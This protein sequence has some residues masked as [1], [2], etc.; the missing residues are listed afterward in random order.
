MKFTLPRITR[1]TLILLVGLVG[2]VN[3]TFI[4]ATPREV[5]VWL[6]GGFVL[7]IPFIHYGDKA[8]DR[9]KKREVEGK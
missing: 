4:E 8:V 1:D 9:A 5:L 3:E 6:Y 2:L 7:G